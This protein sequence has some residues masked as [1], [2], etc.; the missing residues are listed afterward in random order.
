MANKDAFRKRLTRILIERL[1]REDISDTDCWEASQAF[2]DSQYCDHIADLI[3]A[4]GEAP[5]KTKPAPKGH[6][7]QNA[8]SHHSEQTEQA[9]DEMF[10]LYKKR[11]IKKLELVELMSQFGWVPPADEANL[12]VRELLRDFVIL[13]PKSARAALRSALQPAGASDPYLRGILKRSR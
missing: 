3:A 7:V 10:R 8:D 9:L 12:T 6:D 1:L 4:V 13:E 2:R 5:K 11:K